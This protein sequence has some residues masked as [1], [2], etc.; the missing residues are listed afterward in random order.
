[1]MTPI[2]PQEH[3]HAPASALRRDP[4][5][6]PE[7]EELHVSHTAAAAGTGADGGIFVDATAS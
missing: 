6:T 4:W 3:V 5:Q 7:I 1:M 2:Q